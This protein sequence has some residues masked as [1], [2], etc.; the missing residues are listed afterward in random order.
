[1]D[2]SLRDV[3]HVRKVSAGL[4]KSLL[5]EQSSAELWLYRFQPMPGLKFL[6]GKFPP[7]HCQKL[8]VIFRG[9]FVH[10]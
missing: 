8:F 5:N 4:F 2:A 9:R 1:M 10:P 7:G 3:S 6:V